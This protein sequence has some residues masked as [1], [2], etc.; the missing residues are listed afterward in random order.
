MCAPKVCTLNPHL[1]VVHRDCQARGVA[2]LLS[3]PFHADAEAR[4]LCAQRKQL[5]IS[6]CQDCSVAVDAAAA[7]GR[8]GYVPLAAAQM[9]T[10]R[11]LQV[12]QGHVR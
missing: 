12:K 10:E 3:V 11:H 6:S 5:Q 8:P 9:L 2:V 7:A 4:H 1:E